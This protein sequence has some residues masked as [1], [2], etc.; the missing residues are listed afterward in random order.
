MLSANL[1]WLRTWEY[2]GVYMEGGDKGTE[3]GTREKKYHVKDG[4]R[5]GCVLVRM[6]Y[7]VLQ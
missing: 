6:G 4:Q 3:T 2:K 7:A 5:L 1:R